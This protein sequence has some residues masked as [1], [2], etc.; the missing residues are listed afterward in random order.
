MIAYKKEFIELARIFEALS[1]GSFTLKSGRSSPYFFNAGQFSNCAA[2]AK[3][4]RCY[5]KCLVESGIQY[6]MLLGPAYKG[7]PLVTATSIALSEVHG[8]NVPIAY[9]RKEEKTHGEGGM[10]V[11]APL[12]GKVL[13][14]DDVI[15][16]GTAV[17]ETLDIVDKSDAELAGIIVGIDREER[18]VGTVSAVQEIESDF[19]TIVLSLICLGDLI[20]YL[21]G[22]DGADRE[23]LEEMQKY[24]IRYGI[25]TGK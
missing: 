14:V 21:G 23:H 6:D 11:G 12:S 9:N 25:S 13:I 17:R 24:K 7:I 22:A 20:D 3:V 10:L 5:A 4:G 2:L 19:N 1:F 15:T 16:A 8:V 18:G